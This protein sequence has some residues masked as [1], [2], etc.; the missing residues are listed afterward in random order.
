MTHHLE[1]TFPSFPEMC[2]IISDG[3]NL[4]HFQA[5]ALEHISLLQYLVMCS[6]SAKGE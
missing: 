6:L 5:Q 2:Q 1:F 4:L 3:R